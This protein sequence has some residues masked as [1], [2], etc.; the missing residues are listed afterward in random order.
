[1]LRAPEALEET[2]MWRV[3]ARVVRAEAPGQ[4]GAARG[5]RPQL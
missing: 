3:L 4:A 2:D 5:G 1:M